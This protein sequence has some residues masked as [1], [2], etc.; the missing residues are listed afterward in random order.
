V[1]GSRKDRPALRS[2]LLLAASLALVVS[3]AFAGV[4]SA[5]T[6]TGGTTTLELKKGTKK[7]LKKN[8]VKVKPAAGATKSGRTFTFAITGGQLDR[9]TEDAPPTSASGNVQHEAGIKFKC[10]DGKVQVIELVATFGAESDLTGTSKGSSLK[11]AKLDTSAAA[12]TD[13]GADIANVKAKAAKKFAKKLRNVCD[14]DLQG[15]TLG[16]MHV[17]AQANLA[18]FGGTT[19]VAPDPSFAAK[20]GAVDA[21]NPGVSPRPVAPATLDLSGFHFPITNG[22]LNPSTFVGTIEHDGGFI[23]E[24]P[25][26][27][28]APTS[29]T[30][31]D[32]TLELSGPSGGTL[33]GF[34][35]NLSTRAGL[36]DVAITGAP[37]V[38]NGQLTAA[39]V[40][41]LTAGAAELLNGEF[42][43]PDEGGGTPVFAA[44]DLV[45]AGEI[46]A[47]VG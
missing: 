22:E 8:H 2:P 18:V 29:S 40:L 28:A 4:A 39:A 21:F 12:V 25:G 11:L 10:A 1:Q 36:F 26:T 6:L 19:D 43:D 41:T 23:I 38:E 13:R 44:G 27:D 31:L 24:E 46:T 17:D 34:S 20:L 33:T 16:K 47:T 14:V 45:G 9:G 7:K 3:L 5:T 30:V 35:E 42:Q 37:L 32:P 15:K